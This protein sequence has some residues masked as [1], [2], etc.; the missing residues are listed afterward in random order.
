MVTFDRQ[1][2][3]E[4]LEPGK[5][6]FVAVKAHNNIGWGEVGA[7][8]DPIWTDATLCP[9]I[10]YA[11]QRSDT[12][13]MIDWLDPK[14]T[15]GET[16]VVPIDRFEVQ[17]RRIT[18]AGGLATL[19]EWSSVSEHTRPPYLVNGLAPLSCYNVRVRAHNSV[20]EYHPWG[21]WSP[22]SEDIKTKRRF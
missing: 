12:F 10:P 3:V 16:A 6:Y 20:I 5:A 17:V 21:A 9:G 22:P 15:A 13:A 1:G 19:G 2:T 4:G 18:T 7:V 8:S 14:P 11:T